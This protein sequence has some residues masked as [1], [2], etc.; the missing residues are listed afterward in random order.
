M[1][2][3]GTSFIYITFNYSNILK[4]RGLFLNQLTV[5]VM[6]A[7]WTLAVEG[8]RIKKN[9]NIWSDLYWKQTPPKQFAPFNKL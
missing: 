9:L 4:E 8:I 6:K 7:F 5:L 3:M 2:V 1:L